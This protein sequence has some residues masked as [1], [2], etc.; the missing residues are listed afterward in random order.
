M[1]LRWRSQHAGERG[2]PLIVP[3]VLY[4]GAEP[5]QYEREF[6]AYH[7]RIAFPH[8]NQKV[9]VGLALMIASHTRPEGVDTLYPNLGSA[10][11]EARSDR[12]ADARHRLSCACVQGRTP[13]GRIAAPDSLDQT[14]S[15][16][17]PARR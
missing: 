1:W 2:L 16:S 15:R 5:W 10:A 9:E 7:F 8:D 6:A 14:R 12:R 4:Q 11:F 17:W 13:S 3:L